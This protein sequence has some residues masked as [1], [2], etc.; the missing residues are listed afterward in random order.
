MSGGAAATRSW[1]GGEEVLG[2][3]R[4]ESKLGEGGMGAVYLVSHLD[5]PSIR[6]AVKRTRTRDEASRRTFL[7]ELQTWID[8]PPHPNLAAC[9]F[10]RTEA[11][12]VV[13]FAEYLAGGALSSWIADGRIATL[14][15]ALDVAIQFAWGLHQA[16]ELGLVHQDVKPGNVLMTEDGIAKVADFG[17]SRARARAEAGQ[18]VV[19]LGAGG[20]ETVA[21]GGSVLVSFGGLTPAYCSPEQAEGQRLSRRS[22]EWSWAVSVLEM[23]TGGV[24]WRYGTAAPDALEAYVIDGG[25]RLP[26]PDAVATVLRRCLQRAVEA[27]YETMA[28]TANELLDVCR[29]ATGRTYEREVPRCVG[30]DEWA[31]GRLDRRTMYMATWRPPREWIE[32]ALVESGRDPAEAESLLPDCSGSRQAQ[33]VADLIAY[34]TAHGLFGSLVVR[35]RDL[36]PALAEL[37]TEKG[38]VH[39]RLEDLPG[40]KAM[41]GQ[42]V[43]LL[44]RLVMGEGRTELRPRLADAYHHQ[45]WSHIY[46]RPDA[47]AVQ[48]GDRAIGLLTELVNRGAHHDLSASLVRARAVRCL[49]LLLQGKGAEAMRALEQTASWGEQALAAHPTESLAAAVAGTWHFLANAKLSGGQSMAAAD[50]MRRT[51]SILTELVYNRGRRDLLFI[52]AEAHNNYGIWL[53]S[54]GQLDAAVDSL[55]WAANVY[56]GLV[57]D[58]GRDDIA[59]SAPRVRMQIAVVLLARG[60]TEDARQAVLAAER[61]F[62]RLVFAKGRSDLVAELGIC[63]SQ[64]GDISKQTGDRTGA[65]DAYRRAIRILHRRPDGQLVTAQSHHACARVLWELAEH[66]EALQHAAAALKA[67]LGLLPGRDHLRADYAHTLGMCALLEAACGH[68]E[69]A[70]AAAAPA[71]QALQEEVRRAG[72]EDL[73]QMLNAVSQHLGQ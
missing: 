44:E 23:F 63:S 24:T 34:E 25:G 19:P 36:E 46:P 56:D 55:Q 60:R 16:H 72:R 51:I 31:Q 66:P 29:Q 5:E 30:R 28:D 14:E 39:Q 17:L 4:V 53:K 61:E 45:A 37:C 10:F 62:G 27:R 69:Q 18:A 20:T 71:V 2:E 48:A 49:A 8:L 67:Y 54:Q 38:M 15:S 21:A 7:A 73:R 6:F 43:G 41:H 9:R 58:E 64:V 57:V 3:Y 1:V 50:A 68:M 52:L 59:A 42:A 33:A 32:K 12:E 35:G 70:Y 40:A 47:V 11:D 13:I 65:A 22:D 26:M